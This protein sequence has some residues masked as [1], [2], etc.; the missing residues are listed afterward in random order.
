MRS[1]IESAR[2]QAETIDWPLH[3]GLALIAATFVAAGLSKREGFVARVSSLVEPAAVAN[4]DSS[5][6]RNF[7]H[8]VGMLF[9]FCLTQV[10]V[11]EIKIRLLEG[12]AVERWAQLVGC[13]DF[14]ERQIALDALSALLEGEKPLRLFHERAAWYYVI[15]QA[16]PS[17]L[18]SP[19]DSLPPLSDPEILH[20]TLRL[21]ALLATHPMFEHAQDDEWLWE[22]LI[23]EAAKELEVDR[24]AGLLWSCV[25][26]AAANKPSVAEALLQSSSVKR[27]L[28]QLAEPQGSTA[29]WGEPRVSVPGNVYDGSEAR[30]FGVSEAEEKWSLL[31]AVYARTALHRLTQAADGQDTSGMSVEELT[32]R[33]EPFYDEY[34]ATVERPPPPL[35]PLL[36]WEP[37]IEEEL[38]DGAGSVAASALGG[39]VWGAL[40]AGARS[41]RA[42]RTPAWRT[43]VMTAAGACLFEA[44]MRFKVLLIREP[45]G[46]LATQH[47]GAMAYAT[48]CACNVAVSSQILWCAV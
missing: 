43:V 42:A 22:R 28:V 48:T 36:A 8:F 40:R 30:I 35:S 20:D 16:I 14:E 5:D 34:R 29:A 24:T 45:S 46:V 4:S 10:P 2:D 23:D 25:V 31:T 26:A 27:W 9:A 19:P 3:A 32:A 18:H 1:S 17:L 47:Q 38:Y 11:E 21:A 15:V 44:L 13:F 39:A 12:E 33:H 6:G 7:G 41:A 37:S